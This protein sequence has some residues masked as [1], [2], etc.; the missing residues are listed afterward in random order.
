[1][2]PILTTAEHALVC[3]C[4][5]YETTE[6]LGSQ[7]AASEA[8]AI[9]PSALPAKG[10]LTSD[11][12]DAI[13]TAVV[14]GYAIQLTSME[15]P[16]AFGYESDDDAEIHTDVVRLFNRLGI[17]ITCS[18]LDPKSEN[19]L[20]VAKDPYVSS[21]DALVIKEQ[22]D[23]V[24]NAADFANL[25]LSQPLYDSVK[26][27]GAYI[28][29]TCDHASTA[30]IGVS[31]L[32][33][34]DSHYR[35]LS[36]SEKR[37]IEK[38]FNVANE[39][40]VSV[41]SFL[42]KIS[43]VV[44]RNKHIRLTNTNDGIFVAMKKQDYDHSLGLFKSYHGMIRAFKL[45]PNP[46]ASNTTYFEISAGKDTSKVA[47]CFPCGTYMLAA[48][49]P[50]TAVHLGRG[51]N[52]NIPDYQV[53]VAINQ[54]DST[55]LKTLMTSDRDT[56]WAFDITLYY[57][58]GLAKLKGHSV[59]DDLPFKDKADEVARMLTKT[60]PSAR[61]SAV[62]K[63]SEDAVALLDNIPAIFLE[64]LTFEKSFTKRISETL[65]TL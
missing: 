34:Y 22:L 48:D 54:R 49:R 26:Y 40:S 7:S 46:G 24:A 62:R 33:Q 12:A 55:S 30:L 45:V 44:L 60:K 36:T 18:K 10:W 57:L 3:A 56:C 64:A 47:S 58:L 13:C 25:R 65:K 16:V 2:K 31:K 27:Y 11:I 20:I 51:D 6:L 52:W 19:P 42:S 8:Y 5:H 43:P 9:R 23:T 59:F 41:D 61:G 38:K 37:D 21:S 1:M 53:K 4:K 17:T 29:G 28:G 35:A 63:L 15:L 39:V 14:M 32:D 50:A